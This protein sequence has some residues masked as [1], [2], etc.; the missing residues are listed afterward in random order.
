MWIHDDL[1]LGDAQSKEL[2]ASYWHAGSWST[3]VQVTDNE[4]VDFNPQLAF[5]DDTH[6]M[7]VWHQVND[8][9]IP[10]DATLDPAI[11]KKV[12]LVY[13]IYDVTTELWTAPQYLTSNESVDHRMSLEVGSD[14]TIM[15]FWM[16][17][18]DGYLFGT[19]STPDDLVT[20]TWNGVSWTEQII[21][22]NVFGVVS[23]DAAVHSATQSGVVFSQDIDGDLADMSDVEIVF[24]LWD[25]NTW[26]TFSTLTVNTEEDKSPYM[27]Y[28]STGE[29]RLVWMIEDSLQMLGDDW[30]VSPV[31][32]SADKSEF[33]VNDFISVIDQ[34][35]NIALIWQGTSAEGSDILYAI[36]DQTTQTWQTEAQLTNS[37]GV[38]KQISVG[39]DNAG[40]LMLAYA[41][42]HYEEGSVEGDG[43]VINNV[44]LYQSTDL[45]VTHYTPD[46]D[47]TVDNLQLPYRPNPEPGE[48]VTVT[49]ELINSGDWPVDS[50]TLSIYAGDPQAGGTLIDTYTF[51][52]YF[53]AGQVEEV[54]ISWLLPET[55]TDTITLF[56]VVDEADL[57]TERDETNNVDTVQVLLPDPGVSSVKTYYY[58]QYKVVPLAVIRNYGKLDTTNILVEFHQDTIDGTVIYSEVIPSLAPEEMVAISTEIDTTGWAEGYHTYYVTVD[59]ADVIVESDE[60]NNAEEFIINIAPDLVIYTGDITASLDVDGGTVDVRVHNWGT[61]DATNVTLRLYEGPDIDLTRA[62][63][64]EWTIPSLAVDADLTLST[65]LDFLPDNLFAVI[66]PDELI[67]EIDESNN[68]GF[69]EI[70]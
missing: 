22:T 3:P 56:A 51:S 17:N 31:I 14:G 37:V 27:H 28:T 24:T 26:S 60:E 34:N 54:E 10:A 55:A 49:A 59:S 65:T 64:F 62:P 7:A 47:L 58:D 70:D 35:D 42:D 25:G 50:P 68:I 20:A 33:I 12:E 18:A 38:E 46:S 36:Y 48:T 39:F 53:V 1:A 16:R 32:T 23:Y 41:L 44:M 52:G 9:T 19:P 11:S 57:V 43:T 8:S 67:A 13:A 30:A 21:A 61:Y 66:D 6:V 40:Q 69:I 4:M 15:A 2:M 45:H 5:I 63:L 29:K